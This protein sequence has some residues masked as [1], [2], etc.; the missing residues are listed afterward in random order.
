MNRTVT[1][2]DEVGVLW[3]RTSARGVYMTG[4]IG[5]QSVVV[6]R[7]TRKADGDKQPDWRILRARPKAAEDA[8]R[9]IGEALTD[10]T[11]PI[12]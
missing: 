10:D 2:P 12:F 3:E 4:K 9:H 6:F 1:D 8:G 11:D 5:E 7:N